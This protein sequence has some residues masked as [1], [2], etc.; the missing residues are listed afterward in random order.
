MG[1]HATVTGAWCRAAL[2]VHDGDARRARIV[3]IFAYDP[4]LIVGLDDAARAE[5]S[6]RLVACAVDFP[7]GEH[8]PG[9]IT[10]PADLGLLVLDGLV[11]REV[12]LSGGRQG[13]MEL[14]SPGDIVKP[15]TSEEDDTLAHSCSW[16]FLA[17]TAMAI[18]DSRFRVAVARW[19][20]IAS[21]VM[22][23]LAA[24]SRRAAFLLAVSQ[25][26]CVDARVL[27][28][29][30]TLADR[31]GRVTPHGVLVPIRLTHDVV[32]KAVGARRPTVSTAVGHL[33]RRGLLSR[34]DGGGWLL[35]G[36]RPCNVE[37]A[38]ARA[39]ADPPRPAHVPLV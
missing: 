13:W 5:A 19:P 9:Q 8:H 38:I 15:G 20:Q 30:W 22:E 31:V 29:L 2:E 32:A 37:D 35:L 11:A 28:T 12:E 25:L 6:R 18:L 17:P 39:A 3:R 7:E 34:T 10:G 36:P 14:F 21:A 26:R 4:A 16:H 23:R 1:S 33:E 27:I 24:Q